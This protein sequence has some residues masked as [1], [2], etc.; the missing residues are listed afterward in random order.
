MA[1]LSRHQKGFFLAAAAVG[2]ALVWCSCWGSA[3]CAS[4]P[5]S[6]KHS[7]AVQLAYLQDEAGWGRERSCHW[8]NNRRGETQNARE[9]LGLVC[10]HHNKSC[11]AMN[12]A[13]VSA[14]AMRTCQCSPQGSLRLHTERNPLVSL[15]LGASTCTLSFL[16]STEALNNVVCL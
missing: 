7:P 9:T 11:I 10:Q 15:I 12:N 3:L 2:L 13:G 8:S 6:Y 4:L 14:P 16:A 5:L 1:S